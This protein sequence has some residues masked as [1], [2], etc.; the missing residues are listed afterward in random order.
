LWRI[1]L[2]SHRQLCDAPAFST[3]APVGRARKKVERMSGRS[4]PPLSE[5][6]ARRI[7]LLKPSSLGDVVHSL[8]VL[9]ALRRRFPLAHIRWVV[10]QAYADLLHGHPDLDEV[11]TID[12]D[13]A[14]KGL[15]CGAGAVAGVVE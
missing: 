11:L 10:N 3:P 13:A 5:I 14:R 2:A 15:W 9:T 1:G 6:D 12:R 7:V 4:L 8:P